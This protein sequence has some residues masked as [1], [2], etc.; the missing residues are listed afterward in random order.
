[1]LNDTESENPDKK[2][3]L[4]F[5]HHNH[6]LNSIEGYDKNLCEELK[7]PC[8]FVSDHPCCKYEMPLDLVARSRALDGSADLKW[9][10]V[11]LGGPR[12]SS[13]RSLFRNLLP[14]SSKL[15]QKLPKAMTFF[16]RNIK[17][18]YAKNKKKVQIPKYHYDGGP[19][20][21][22]TIVGLCWRLHYVSCPDVTGSNK[23]T[24]NGKEWV[25]AKKLKGIHPCCQLL[26]KPATGSSPVASRLSRW[27]HH[28]I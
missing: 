10:P 20:M 23:L 24:G 14:K 2:K 6:M 22:S 26:R 17:Y 19:E 7:V 3:A 12:R 25:D 18:N 13:G 8:R 1:M 11:S 21:T 27:L 5:A 4:F 28:K 15:S 16:N 9:R